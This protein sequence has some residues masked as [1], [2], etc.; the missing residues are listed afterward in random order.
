MDIDGCL[1]LKAESLSKHVSQMR[2]RT[3]AERLTRM[4][5]WSSEAGKKVGVP[6]AE[7]FRHICLGLD[8]KERKF[9]GC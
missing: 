2:N 9:L 6:Y 5:S 8:S 3:P 1:E 4:Q 7:G